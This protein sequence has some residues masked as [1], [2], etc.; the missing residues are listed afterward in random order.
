MIVMSGIGG[1]E[2]TEQEPS[3]KIGVYDEL[4][5][6]R[7]VVVWGPPATEAA[8]AKLYPEKKSL[9]YDD[10]D[11]MKAREEMPTYIEELQRH[12]VRV[13]VAKDLVASI[14][15]PVRLTRGQTLDLLLARGQEVVDK[16]GPKSR[17]KWPG[18]Q[19]EIEQALD[20]E[21]AL[22]GP[23][24]AYSMAIDLGLKTKM[25][26][27]NILYARDQ[28]NVLLSTRVVSSMK[29]QIR[30]EEI[31]I[32]ETVY[33]VLMGLDKGVRIP[34]SETF[35]GGDAYVVDGTVYV[36]Q[37]IR[38]SPGAADLIY[39]AL[40]PELKSRGFRFASV[41]DPEAANKNWKKGQ[42]TMHI[43]TWSFFFGDKQVLV[44]LSEAENRRVII[45]DPNINEGEPVDVGNFLDY[46]REEGYKIHAASTKDQKKF[47]CN[48]I[49]IDRNTVILPRKDNQ[50]VTETL[51]SEGQNVIELDL[52]EITK[53][54][55][56]AHCI[57]GT[58]LRSK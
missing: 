44:L 12:G 11:I 48:N 41:I 1:P 35:E 52:H 58:L 54:Y 46:L 25:P 23:E 7:R 22:Y 29:Y 38:T 36:G 19:A 40:A 34:E 32:Y 55:G 43:D 28:M 4:D 3:S 10:M 51:E 33:Q 39:E 37:G 45:R 56:A 21:E 5:P 42:D 26:L 31:P 13:I 20:S 50:G 16:Y 8:L 53:G 49:A 2:H 24:T 57:T 30:R 17:A 18:V 14:A 47:G 9:F 27:G 6:L 15:E